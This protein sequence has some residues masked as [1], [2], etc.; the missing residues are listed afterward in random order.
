MAV[1]G[2]VNGKVSNGRG[3]YC[4][5][6]GAGQL[7][8]L[9]DQ[10]RR[11]ARPLSVSGTACGACRRRRHG[12]VSCLLGSAGSARDL[13]TQGQLGLGIFPF[14]PAP[15]RWRGRGR[16]KRL[17][18]HYFFLGTGCC[19][20]PFFF[21]AHFLQTLVLYSLLI[22]ALFSLRGEGPSGGAENRC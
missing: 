6:L 9:G 1:A 8:L 16:G 5:S 18:L 3:E 11:D 20:V 13:E 21:L 12:G 10:L 19:L 14:Y 2:V 7:L 22:P 15:G 4:L 17:Y